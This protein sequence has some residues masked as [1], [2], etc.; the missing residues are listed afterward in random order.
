MEPAPMS[1]G[2]FDAFMRA[3]TGKWARVVNEAAIPQQ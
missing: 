2:D 3:E 1:P